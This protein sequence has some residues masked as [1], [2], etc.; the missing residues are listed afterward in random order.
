MNAV[1]SG[2][3]TRPSSPSPS[4]FSFHTL[5]ITILS[6]IQTFSGA[7]LAI[8]HAYKQT[9]VTIKRVNQAH[10]IPPPTT[11]LR[12]PRSRRSV[13]LPLLHVTTATSGRGQTSPSPWH[14][15][16]CSTDNESPSDPPSPTDTRIVDLSRPSLVMV[17]EILTT[18]E[19]FASNIIT[20]TLLMLSS[21]IGSFLDRYAC[22]RCLV[23]DAC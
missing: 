20:S 17:A 9:L 16:Q 5:L 23:R 3:P 15:A 21:V 12:L 22:C 2:V 1:Q 11:P 14:S 6:A 4:S 8:I 18:H 19:R 10:V 13:S 7:C